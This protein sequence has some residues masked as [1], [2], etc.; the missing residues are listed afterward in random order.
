M[1]LTIPVPF[2]LI[3]PKFSNHVQ[4]LAI[5][6]I[7]SSAS[8][9]EESIAP[10]AKDIIATLQPYLTLECTEE[11]QVLMMQV[12]SCQFFYRFYEAL[13]MYNVFRTNGIVACNLLN[14]Y[15]KLLL[16]FGER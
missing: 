1:L 16:K 7:G 8:S 9:V 4:E 15:Q 13:S 3:T 10:F 6:L 11:N 14:V 5:S 2:Q 12:S